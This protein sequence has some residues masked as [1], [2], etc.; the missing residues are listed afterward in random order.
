MSDLTFAQA[1]LQAEAQARST[2]DAALHERLSCAVAIAKAGKVFQTTG[3]QWQVQSTREPERS[4][5]TNGTCQCADRHF[6]Q[7]RF[8]KHQLAMFLTRRVQ[9]LMQEPAPQ[10][11]EEDMLE[12]Y[13]DNDPEEPPAVGPQQP[14]PAVPLPEAPVSITLKAHLDGH[15]VLVTLRGTDFASVKVQ[16]EQASAW[17]KAHAPAPSPAVQP[18]R[19]GPGEGWCAKHQTAL[20]VNHGK[21]GRTWLSHRTAEGQWCKGK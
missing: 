10:P 2:L 6:N 8:C 18:A 16:V 9:A 13:P 1:L 12:P 20:N 17:L 15:E 14:A 3:G 5:T 19:Q 21:D 7:P 11:M 4:Y